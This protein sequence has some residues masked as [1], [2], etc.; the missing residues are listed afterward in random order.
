[1]IDSSL[2]AGATVCELYAGQASVGLAER[3]Y[4]TAVELGAR[5]AEI[6]RRNLV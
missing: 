6:A 5:L 1:V 3:G 4:I 2:P